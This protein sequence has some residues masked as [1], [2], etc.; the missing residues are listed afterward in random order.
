[1][2]ID[3]VLVKKD[4]LGYVQDVRVVREMGRGTSDHHVVMCKVR[5]VGAGLR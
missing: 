5:L 2:I 1:M 3:M 4:V